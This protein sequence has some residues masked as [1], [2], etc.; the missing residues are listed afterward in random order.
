MIV[1]NI[2]YYFLIL[3]VLSCTNNKVPTVNS[4]RLPQSKQIIAFDMKMTHLD[5]HRKKI[6][7]QREKLSKRNK[8]KNKK[9]SKTNHKT[10]NFH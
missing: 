10:F 8:V 4:K 9:T 7:K 3:I 1:K 2:I 5:R 6:T